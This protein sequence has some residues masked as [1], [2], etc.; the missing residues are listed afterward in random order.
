MKDKDSTILESAIES[1]SFL[2][3]IGMLHQLANMVDQEVVWCNKDISEAHD[4]V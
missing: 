2:E 4:G 3:K 1:V